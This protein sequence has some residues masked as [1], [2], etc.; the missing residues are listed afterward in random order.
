MVIGSGLLRRWLHRS[1][2]L[3]GKD[4]KFCKER[5]QLPKSSRPNMAGTMMIVSSHAIAHVDSR[6]VF[7]ANPAT[8]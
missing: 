1:L 7:K 8:D 2:N 4:I 5:R 3:S 6:I